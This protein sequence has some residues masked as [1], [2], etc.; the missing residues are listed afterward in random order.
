MAL[1]LSE[2]EEL[3]LL[4]LKKQKAEAQKS[5][6]QPEGGAA[7]GVF[8]KQRAVP[9]KPETRERMGK[10][11]ESAAETLGF[12]VPEAP[13]F[14]P[15]AVGASA[16]LGAAAGALG[17]SMLQRGGQLVSKI[18]TAPTRA[19]G[20][21]MQALG[22]G[23]KAIP[24]GRRTAGTA[25]AMGGTELAGQAGEQVG[26][27]RAATTAAT[28]GMAPAAGRGAAGALLGKPTATREQYARAAE[29][30]GFK[31]SPA[32]VRAEMPVPARGASFSSESN[33]NLA[34][35]LVSAATGVEA[36]E[37]SPTFV[38]KRLDD[39]G[40]EFNKVYKGKTFNIDPQAVQALKEIASNEMQLPS[41]AQVS[42]VKNTA[43]EI[44]DNFQSLA[45]RTGAQ[46]GT[47]AIEGDALQRLRTDLLG[48]ARSASQRQDAHAIYELVDIID[49]SI[50][51]NHPQIA[52]Q[53]EI[54]R[55]QYRNTVILEDAIRSGAIQGGDV[56]LERLGNMLVG[57]KGGV[58]NTRDIDQL[59]EM[60]R[61]LKMRARWESEGRQTTPGESMLGQVLGTGADI[62]GRITG[63]RT[64][65]AR[66][67]QRFY[68][69]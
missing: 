13:E 12:K 25:A 2:Q 8:P 61:E 11:E 43:N 37:I 4:R 14:S 56:S 63:L 59:A 39:L 62:A 58:R 42:A 45:S 52:R 49:S 29:K 27:P 22:T 20:G 65:A 31:V 32:Q 17:P 47:F 34:N 30:L 9:T 38:R 35:Q 24:T 66:A 57:R 5:P 51:R 7:F 54:L 60:G 18:P 33:Q 64:P 10:F 48:A 41:N 19:A 26:I 1:N 28:L 69:E 55:P 46:P 3:E 68:S 67:V 53:L 15:Q 40:Q 36:K 16:G 21:L 23:L 44:V 6:A 50:A